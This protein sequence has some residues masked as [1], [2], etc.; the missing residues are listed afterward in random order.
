MRRAI[1]SIRVELEDL[2]E[3]DGRVVA[4][5]RGHG[6]GRASELA[7]DSSFCQVWTVREG[8]AFRMEEYATRAAALAALRG[9]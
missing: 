9:A 5:V 3:I 2:A 1:E 4:V 7:L 8:Q 6:R